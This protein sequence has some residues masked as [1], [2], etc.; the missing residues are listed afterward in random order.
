MAKLFGSNAAR[1]PDGARL[2]PLCVVQKRQVRDGLV[3]LYAI[4]R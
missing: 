2:L 1:S 3:L 4:N